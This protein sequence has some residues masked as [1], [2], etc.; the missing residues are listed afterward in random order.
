MLISFQLLTLLIRLRL[1]LF[2][3]FFFN[4]T[5]TTEIY[6]LS[7]HDALPISKSRRHEIGTR[8]WCFVVSCFR[9]FVPK[10]L[11]LQQVLQRRERTLPAEANHFVVAAPAI[12]L[13]ETVLCD[14]YARHIDPVLLHRD[15]ERHRPD[16]LAIGRE[17]ERIGDEEAGGRLELHDGSAEHAAESS[18]Y[19]VLEISRRPLDDVGAERA[20]RRHRVRD[21]PP[22][23]QRVGVEEGFQDAPGRRGN[24]YRDVEARFNH[25]RLTAEHAEHAENVFYS[26]ISARSAVVFCH[27]PAVVL[28]RRSRALTT[29]SFTSRISVGTWYGMP[30]LIVHSMPPPRA[31]CTRSPDPIGV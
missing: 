22:R 8:Y 24:H 31:F 28:G 15:F 4:D 7:L 17:P 11:L 10:T 25:A 19:F 18:E 9:G 13:F 6:T 3:F 20:R 27:C 23:A 16:R 1:F 14:A 2:V 30:S 29:M 5:A 12:A 21:T 26:A